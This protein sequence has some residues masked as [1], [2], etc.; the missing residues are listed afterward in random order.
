M[1]TKHDQE[2]FGYMQENHNGMCAYNSRK[3]CSG[4]C[5][6]CPYDLP[7]HGFKRVSATCCGA[8]RTENN[9]D[10]EGAILAR[11]ELYYD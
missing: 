10:Y 3:K 2:I 11:Q 9:F 7:G 8:L 5:N 4:C 6:N 1:L